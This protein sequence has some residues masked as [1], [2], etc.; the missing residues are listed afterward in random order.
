MI[1]PATYGENLTIN[2]SLN[3]VGASSKTTIIDGGGAGT[4]VAIPNTAS[5]VAISKL[6]IRNGS[7]VRGGGIFNAGTL[8]IHGTIISGNSAPSGGGI[9][10]SGM[11]TISYSTV[12]GNSAAAPMIGGQGGGIDN[13]GVMMISNTSITGNVAVGLIRI[14]PPPPWAF[15]G[16]ILNAGTLTISNSTLAANAVGISG[17]RGHGGALYNYGTV[18]I[19]NS[20]VAGNSGE[21]IY[22]SSNFVVDLTKAQNTIVANN[23]AGNCSSNIGIAYTIK[24]LGYNLSSDQTCD[25][26]GPGDLNNID[27]KLGSLGYYGGATQTIPLLASS[28]A[29]DAGNPSGCTDAEGNLLKIDQRG[30]PRPDV[31]DKG[32]CDMGAYESQSDTP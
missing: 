18:T 29:I 27:P 9:F 1:A 24:S 26:N 11:L 25:F 19:S 21:G 17:Y 12:G 8:T 16:G 23:S 2:F 3:V 30:R 28:P 5:H 32:G 14:A 13:G 7:A 31:E 4:V 15:G 6:T 20:T 10:N 22:T